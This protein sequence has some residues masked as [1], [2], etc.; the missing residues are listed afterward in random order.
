MF[1][2]L[3]SRSLLYIGAHA[4]ATTLA[5]F[6]ASASAGVIQVS[7][8]DLSRNGLVDFED[9]EVNIGA[10]VH[11][12]EIF[13][14]GLAQFGERFAGQALTYERQYYYS[15][16]NDHRNTYSDILG[17]TASTQLTLQ[18][19]SSGENVTIVRGADNNK[20]NA[21]IA[22][23]G[24]AKHPSPHGLGEGSI[25][26]LFDYD[27]SE[28]GFD[29][30]GGQLGSAT[31]QFWDR[32]GTLMDTLELEFNN[33]LGDV[34]SLGFKTDDSS[35][36]IAGVSI[37]NTDLGGI[38]FDNFVFDVISAT[39]EPDTSPAPGDADKPSPVVEVAEPP[40]SALGLLFFFSALALRRRKA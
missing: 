32:Q 16:P 22:G 4:V 26:V 2:I 39:S 33:D 21:A 34:K 27:Q 9:L 6:C 37:F 31:L 25:A 36:S 8:G 14:S 29:L 23:N 10:P 28:F 30:L 1:N 19:G 35:Y 38:G 20:Q 7:Y 3:N 17:N 24:K 5:L 11:V 15:N 13:R 40:L 18:P 12:E